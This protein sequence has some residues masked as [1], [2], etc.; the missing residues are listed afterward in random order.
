VFGLPNLFIFPVL[1]GT[2]V[3]SLPFYL[4]SSP[5]SMAADDPIILP[6]TQNH[7]ISL[8]AAQ[9]PSSSYFL[10]LDDNPSS[11]VATPILQGS[12][13]YLIWSRN[14]M[15]ALIYKDKFVFVS[16]ELP[17]PPLG[18]AL[19]TQWIKCDTMVTSWISRSVSPNIASTIAF[20]DT[21]KDLW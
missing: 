10:H 21:A 20:F 5:S 2:R 6:E 1:C 8:S 4:F 14:M 17:R 7:H 19:F 18:D 11:V 13:N 3:P 15:K 16:S 9:N 12:N